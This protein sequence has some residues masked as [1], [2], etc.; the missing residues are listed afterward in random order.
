MRQAL[1]ALPMALASHAA[2]AATTL[3]VCA[4][5]CDHAE[6]LAAWADAATRVQQPGETVLIKISDG[7]YPVHGQFYTD[8]P[9]ADRIQV[10]GNPGAPEK[11]VL[12]FVNI[13]GTNFSGF[14]AIKGGRIG[15]VDGV[16]IKGNGARAGRTEWRQDSYGA[17][18]L[19]EGSGSNVG[20]GPHVVVD[21]FYYGVLADQGGRVTADGSAFRN[22]GDANLLARFGGVIQCRGCSARTAAH[23]FGNDTET[24]GYNALAEGGSLF[25][26]GSSFGDA[27]VACVAAQSNGI[28]WAHRVTATGCLSSGARASQN[29]FL[30]LNGAHLSHSAV[31]AY[32]T[33]GGGLN[34]NAAELNH[35]AREGVLLDGGH[36]AGSRVSVHDN[37]ASGIKVMKQGRGEFYK[38]RP[39]LTG[40][41]GGPV[42]VERA[43]GCT[44]ANAPCSPASTLILD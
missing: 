1:L 34:L 33:T 26:D 20:L 42:F 36:A 5:G 21:G 40:N 31:G 22:A 19:A 18:I 35:N 24:L 13:A 9:C 14:A 16:L 38:T 41:A 6:P 8:C 7:T 28:A 3:T 44:G 39:L 30:E 17:A 27:Q 32:A 43:A 12:D 37:G 23:I 11:V 15:L 10:V 25:V 4:S 2:E 29:G